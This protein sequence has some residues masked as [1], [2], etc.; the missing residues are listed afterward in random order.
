MAERETTGKMD[1]EALRR[2]IEGGAPE[3][4]LGF[5]ADYARIRVLNGVAAP[6]E[7]RGKAEI[8][9]YLRAVFGRTTTHRVENEAVGPEQV[10]FEDVCQ[11]QDGA[12]VVVATTLEIRGGKISHQVDAVTSGE[13]SDK[14][15]PGGPPARDPERPTEEHAPGGTSNE[16]W[17]AVL[18]PGGHE[19]SERRSR[20]RANK[21][22]AKEEKR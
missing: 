5:Y 15:D 17:K 9:A 21:T 12:A 11:Y 3:A 20:G 18:R 16:V 10:T 4:M 2:A 19:A 7:L 1:F 14:G 13:G 22:P 6:F 8:R